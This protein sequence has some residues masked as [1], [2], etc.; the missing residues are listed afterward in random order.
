MTVQMKIFVTL[1]IKVYPLYTFMLLID[2]YENVIL[3][4]LTEFQNCRFC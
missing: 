2:G 4:M 1:K 3:F